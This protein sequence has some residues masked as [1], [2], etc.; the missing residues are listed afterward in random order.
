MKCEQRVNVAKLFTKFQVHEFFPTI[1]TIHEMRKIHN[2]AL[3]KCDG[4]HSRITALIII[5][6]TY[7]Y[8]IITS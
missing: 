3:S 1:I 2:P 7:M 6:I 4:I 5:C 8:T